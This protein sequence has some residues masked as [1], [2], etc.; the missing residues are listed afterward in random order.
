[1]SAARRLFVVGNGP[2]LAWTPLDLLIGEESWGMARIHLL[3]L[4]Y[5]DTKWRPTRYWW[6][7][8]PQNAQDMADVLW[9]MRQ[10]YPCWY[11]RD[12]CE[13][14]AG[15]YVPSGENDAGQW[16]HPAPWAPEPRPLPEHV[17]SWEYCVDHN[18]GL[19][20]NPD[21]SPDPRRPEGWH[22]DG[23][24]R[25][26]KYGSTANVALQQAFLEG[27][28]PIYL[29]GMDLGFAGHPRGD[30]P[31]HFTRGYNSRTVEP[32]RARADNDTHVDFYSHART[33]CDARG[34]EIYNATLGGE[35]EV[36][37]RVEFDAL[38][39]SR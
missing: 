30:D 14:I 6:S 35:L 17:H 34:V 2:S 26:C 10:G 33:W 11:R 39:R 9:H 28:N 5:A 13:I 32:E 21:G 18:A 22:L 36:F 23:S 1:V 24:G 27:Y 12:V 4:L 37:P 38:F 8:H 29:L 16:V 15:S 19:A 31:D 20:H 3:Y 25:L 7:D